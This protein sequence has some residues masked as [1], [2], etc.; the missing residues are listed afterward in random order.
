MAYLFCTQ[1]VFF[2][3]VG[4]FIF[5][6]SCFSVPLLSFSQFSC[7]VVSDSLW[8][9]G[10]QHARVPCPSPTPRA[11]SNSC[12]SSQWHHPTMSSSVIPLLLLL[13]IF[14][15]IRV[16]SD[17]SVLH[18]RLPKYWS[19][20]ISPSSKYSRLISFRIDWFDLLAVKS[21]NFLVLSFLYGPTLT[22]IHEYWKNH[23][24]DQIDLGWQ[25]NISGFNMLSRLVIT[26]LPRSKCLLISWLQSPSAVFLEPK[27]RK[28]VTVSIV[29]PSICH[30]VMGLDAIIFVFW[31]LSFKPPFSLSLS[32][33]GSLV[34][35]HFL[36]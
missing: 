36:P 3:V 31:M 27:K 17:E 1:W 22:S 25:S 34:L 10:L 7:S 15:S 16:F 29:S 13:S 32:S 30:E 33:R 20:S 21:I 35:L 18:I 28:S 11:C 9:Q 23:S 2:R 19:F 5:N 4:S 6:S 8:P 24:F 12:P 26:F 14:P